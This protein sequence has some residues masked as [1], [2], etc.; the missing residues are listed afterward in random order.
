MYCF[1]SLFS[2][3]IELKTSL[4]FGSPINDLN[5]KLGLSSPLKPAFISLLP[6]SIIIGCFNDSLISYIFIFILRLKR[7]FDY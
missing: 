1:I 2:L 7:N 6:K 3:Y 4:Y 5:I